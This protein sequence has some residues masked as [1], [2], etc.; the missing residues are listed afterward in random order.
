MQLINFK[1]NLPKIVWIFLMDQD[2]IFVEYE[3]MTF[4]RV[5]Q[6]NY[7][8]LIHDRTFESHNDLNMVYWLDRYEV[9]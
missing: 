8:L 6:E 2:E 3:I 7:N 4:E 1:L 5:F 9:H